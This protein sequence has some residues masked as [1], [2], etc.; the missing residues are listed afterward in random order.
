MGD[1]R[2]PYVYQT[3]RSRVRALSELREFPQYEDFIGKHHMVRD[4]LELFARAPWFD[5]V[6][7]CYHDLMN[8]Y[9]V[10]GE[11]PGRIPAFAVGTFDWAHCRS[12]AILTRTSNGWMYVNVFIVVYVQKMD[13]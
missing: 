3:S 13:A 8:Q 11:Y 12:F 9:L 1:Y 4:H 2:S 10:A 6:V 7:I 5:L